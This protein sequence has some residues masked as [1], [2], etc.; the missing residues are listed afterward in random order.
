MHRKTRPAKK[1]SKLTVHATC[2]G[3]GT[4]LSVAITFVSPAL[5]HL[6]VILPV[7]PSLGQE[8]LDRIFNL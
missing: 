6:A 7:L 3:I 1:H 2:I 8:I 5:V 4:I